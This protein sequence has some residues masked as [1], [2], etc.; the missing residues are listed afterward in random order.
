MTRTPSAVHVTPGDGL[1]MRAVAATVWPRS[2]RVV[3]AASL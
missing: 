2:E 3:D 1:S